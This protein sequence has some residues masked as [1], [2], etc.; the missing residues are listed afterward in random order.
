MDDILRKSLDDLLQ[1]L[2]ERYD[3]PYQWELFYQFVG[4]SYKLKQE[5]RPSVSTLTSILRE[6][7]VPQPGS[8]AVLYAHGLYILAVYESIPIYKEG[9]NP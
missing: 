7:G 6:A 8:L 9:F 3:T 2:K 5:N 4:M 1:A